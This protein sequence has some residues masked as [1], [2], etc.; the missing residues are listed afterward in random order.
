MQLDGGHG[1]SLVSFRVGRVLAAFALALAF[2]ASARMLR[3]ATPLDGRFVAHLVSPTAAR[4]RL[5]LYL[6]GKPVAHGLTIHHRVC[7]ERMLTLQVQ[8]LRGT[9]TFTVDITKP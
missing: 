4:M 1:G 5:V 8:R 3:I 7:G 2:P 9:G 6:S